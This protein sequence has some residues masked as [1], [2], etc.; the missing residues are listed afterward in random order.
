VRY[1]LEYVKIFAKHGLWI[2]TCGMKHYMVIKWL[3]KKCVYKG[4][5]HMISAMNKVTWQKCI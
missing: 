4:F 3:W 2:K 5:N 1:D